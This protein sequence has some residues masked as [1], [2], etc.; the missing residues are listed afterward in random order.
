MGSS[1]LKLK[2]IVNFNWDVDYYPGHLS[3]VHKSG[4]FVAYA[5]LTPG[6]NEGVVRVL[7]QKTE[8]RTLLKGMKGRVKDLAFAHTLDEIILG[9]VDEVGNLFVFLIK[10]SPNESDLLHEKIL[11]VNGT[12][13]THP[14]DHH[15]IIWCPYLPEEDEVEDPSCDSGSPA[16][17][18]VLTH[19]EVATMWNVSMVVE[20]KGA[21]PHTDPSQIEQGRLEVRSHSKAITAASF[22]P[23]GTALA[24]AS[25][26]GEVKFFQVY[27]TGAS[28]EKP[29][30]LHQWS[31]HR[32]SPVTSLFFLDNHKD[33]SIDAQFWKYAV[34]GSSHNSE[35][36]IWSCESWTCLQTLTFESSVGEDDEIDNEEGGEAFERKSKFKAAID[37]R[38]KFI[39]LSDIYR[40]NIYI[41]QLQE[42]S[43]WT[44]RV[45]GK[46]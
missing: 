38:A 25:L 18:L 42:V 30:C 37:L 44:L 19:N 26:D 23:D 45:K 15:R 24:T 8:Q 29:R 34:T 36:K 21:G 2:T 10:N 28:D 3:S 39:I 35:L 4:V 32:G 41:L 13:P 31:P 9:C 6:K 16:K 20:S 5:I 17:L 12:E 1:H 14:N 43:E 40:K 22:S 46:S 7:N 33:H 11:Q 27:M